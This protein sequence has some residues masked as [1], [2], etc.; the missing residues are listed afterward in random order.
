VTP[1]WCCTNAASELQEP[2]SLGSG[3][4]VEQFLSLI[5]GKHQGGGG[6]LGGHIQQPR[7]RGGPGLFQPAAQP[8]HMLGLAGAFDHP[9]SGE[10]V[11]GGN[12]PRRSQSWNVHAPHVQE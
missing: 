3:V 1:V 2:H 12:V 6:L 7:P 5:Q 8:I 10:R 9:H 4:G 11:Q